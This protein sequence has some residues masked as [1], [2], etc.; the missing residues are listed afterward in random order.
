MAAGGG[1]LGRATA[2]TTSRPP[3]PDPPLGRRAQ[4][5]WPWEAGSAADE[6]LADGA[7]SGKWGRAEARGGPAA[8]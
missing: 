7:L 6:A 3:P 2:T 5:K 4:R 8:L 1:A